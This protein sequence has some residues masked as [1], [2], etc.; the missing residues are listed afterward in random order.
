M[1]LV[2][3]GGFRGTRTDFVHDPWYLEKKLGT[4]GLRTGWRRAGEF[5]PNSLQLGF[6]KLFL[7]F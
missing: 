6:S 2:S 3:F 1:L 5:S 7:L 4:S